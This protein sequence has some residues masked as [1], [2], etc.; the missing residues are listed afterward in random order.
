MKRSLER[1]K[2]KEAI[3]A[4][5]ELLQAPRPERY[6]EWLD[7]FF[8][9]LGDKQDPWDL[10]WGFTA[11][12]RELADL[13]RATLVYSGQDLA[14]YSDWQAGCGLIALLSGDFSNTCHDLFGDGI[15]DAQQ[16]A[17]CLAFKPFYMDCLARRSPPVLGHLSE[18]RG[19]GKFAYLTYM[20]WDVS[21]LGRLIAV[22]LPG[23]TRSALIDTLH[24]VLVEPQMNPACVESILH[25]FGHMVHPH[26]LYRDQ[27][28][29]AIDDY[30]KKGPM[31][32][33]ELLQYAQAARSGC[34][35]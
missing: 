6:E 24:Q 10:E 17:L 23:D 4:V 8:G 34:V 3:N 30:I 14:H 19:N 35:Q 31:A 22:T 32:R 26:P 13:Y 2:N 27:I 5:F 25:G 1:R 21:S 9:R 29:A 12:A 20:L 7:F 11:P 18:T 16:L 15:T 28:V 33:P